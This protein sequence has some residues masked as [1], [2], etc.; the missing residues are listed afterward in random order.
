M[1]PPPCCP[2]AGRQLMKRFEIALAMCVAANLVGLTA[3]ENISSLSLD[4]LNLN[5]RTGSA[6][7]VS[8][9]AVMRIAAASRSSGDFNNAVS[10][11]RHAA[12]MAP[13]NPEPLVALGGTLLDMGQIDEAIL[14]YNAALKL[15][16]QHPEALR[17]LAQ[18]YLRSGRPEL[19][20]APLAIAY[21][22]TPNDPQLLL[23][24]GVAADYAGQQDEAQA[25]YQTALTFAPG[26]RVLSLDLALSLALSGKF[27]Q[28]IALLKP[29][30]TKT[31]SS[32]PERETLALIY[33]LKGDRAA[34]RKLAAIDLDAASVD[35]NLATYESLRQLAPRERA[36]AVLSASPV[37]RPQS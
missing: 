17:G 21:Q 29:I 15:N 35:H 9:D 5:G 12:T 13:E 11:Y 3:C 36:R 20:D 30:A 32:A 27:D 4:P 8:P 2:I 34:A 28:S 33:G 7:V 10:L 14:N 19:A 23:L 22:S 18:A 6:P 16:P 24:M 37:G 1:P 26:D 31:D 25:C